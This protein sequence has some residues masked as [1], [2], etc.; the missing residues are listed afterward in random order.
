[1]DSALAALLRSW[2]F[3]PWLIAPLSVAAGLYL[4]GWWRLHCQMPQRFGVW[5]PGEFPVRSG[6][7]LASAGIAARGAGCSVTAG[8]Y[9]AASSAHDAS[10]TAACLRCADTTAAAELATRGVQ[11]WAGI[12]AGLEGVTMAR[13]PS[14]AP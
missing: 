12:A 9:G 4:R 11:A 13:T 1:M 3:D 8:P 14:H 7:A 6:Y 10:P 2:T 5:A